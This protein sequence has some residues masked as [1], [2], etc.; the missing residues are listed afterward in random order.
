M[1]L[2]KQNWSLDGSK[3]WLTCIN[4]SISHSLYPY[5]TIHGYDL[6]EGWRK[7]W[8]FWVVK[9]CIIWTLLM[10]CDTI[11]VVIY[12]K[13]CKYLLIDNSRIEEVWSSS[14]VK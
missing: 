14:K 11:Y 5:L 3:V 7:G 13:V 4:Y 12:Y 1:S 8:S 10:N 2:A 6:F 9:L